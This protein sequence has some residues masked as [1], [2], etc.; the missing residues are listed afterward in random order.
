MIIVRRNIYKVVLRET[1]MKGN[2]HD[3]PVSWESKLKGTKFKHRGDDS[4]WNDL[5]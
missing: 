5:V 4:L 2:K 1:C 3:D